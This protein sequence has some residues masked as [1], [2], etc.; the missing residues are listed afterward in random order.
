MPVLENVSVSVELNC[1]HLRPDHTKYISNKVQAK[2]SVVGCVC[3]QSRLFAAPWTVAGQVPLSVGYS[4]QGSWNVLPFPPAGDL[5]N[6]GIEHTSLASSALA[7][8]FFTT[9]PPGQ[10]F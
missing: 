5:P 10:F 7:G 3:A 4:T 8:K 2:T 6:P 1:L 9:A